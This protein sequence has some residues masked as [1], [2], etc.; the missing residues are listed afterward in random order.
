M[1]KNVVGHRMGPAKGLI[2]VW[3]SI[4][5]WLPFPRAALAVPGG[6]NSAATITGSFADACRDFAAHSSKNISHVEIHYV[7]GRV[8]KD[9]SISSPDHAIDGGAGDEIGFAVVKSGTTSEQ[10]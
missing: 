5:A 3:V 7:D 10:F 6:G 1:P 9:E 2:L 8:V 4:L